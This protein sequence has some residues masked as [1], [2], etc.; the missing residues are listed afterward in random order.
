MPD[1]ILI[2]GGKT[3]L[4]AAL[5]GLKNFKDRNFK[6]ISAVKPKGKHNKV[7]HFPDENLG[8]IETDNA[9]MLYLLTN[10]RD[11]AHNL[12]NLTHANIRDTNHFYKLAIF[13]PGFSENE[14][15]SILQK[16]G[17][18]EKL[19][20]TDK[21]ELTKLFGKESAEQILA[22]VERSKGLKISFADNIIPIRFDEKDGSAE[23]LQPIVK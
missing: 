18:I 20:N 13:L 5:E 23:D 1:L 7:S 3:Q 8:R 22:E 10:L 14:R 2:D 21:N 6:V 16:I 11:S 19:K 4:N 17:S 9:D 12:A 15:R